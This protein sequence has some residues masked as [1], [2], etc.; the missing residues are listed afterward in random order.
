MNDAKVVV[1]LDFDNK[2]D[3]LA[4]VDKIQP[5][6]CRLK[7]GK[8][9]FTYFGPEFVKELTSRGFDVFLDLKFHDIPNTVAKA[10][11]A[12]A[13]LGVWMVNVHASGGSEMMIKAKQALEK[14]GDKAPLLIAVTV[15]TSMGEEDL[16]GLGITKS[17][18]E[19]VMALAKLTKKAGL[20]GVVCSAW[21]AES[22]K[23][24]LGSDFKLITPGI[25][26][27]GTPSDDQKRIMTPAEAM[28]VGVDY[29]VIGRPITKAENPQN[30]LQ[31]IN[32]SLTL[33]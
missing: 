6:D 4:F 1:A 31:S 15:L 7:V 17:P 3:A 27:A 20:D 8:E 29:L 24:N 30:V 14:Y 11:T 9:M 19:Q 28:G 21:E 18:A 33:T 10:V 16:L 13:E 32:S 22:L 5:N 2:D 25:R 26:P 12:A 23:T